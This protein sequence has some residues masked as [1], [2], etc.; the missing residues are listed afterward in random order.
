MAHLV[1]A[2]DDAQ[3]NSNLATAVRFLPERYIMGAVSGGA[4]P[5]GCAGSHNTR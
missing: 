4:R 5:A 3:L 2:R 1:S